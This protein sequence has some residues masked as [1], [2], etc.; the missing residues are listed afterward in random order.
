MLAFACASVTS[1]LQP[2]HDQQPVE[3]VVDLFRLE[4]E[5]H[6]EA[7]LHPIGLAG[8]QDADDGVRLRVDA[9]LAAEDRRDRR[10]SAPARSGS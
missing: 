8:C 3:I 7:R 2:P 5:R 4:R 1:R 6:I 9:D 10:R